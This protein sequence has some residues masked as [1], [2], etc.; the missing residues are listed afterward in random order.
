M[1]GESYYHT[2]Q[3]AQAIEQYE[4]A[5]NLYLSFQGWPD[6]TKLPET[7]RTNPR[8]AN[9]INWATSSRRTTIGVYDKMLVLMGRLDADRAIRGRR[10]V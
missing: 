3:Y 5:L 4:A 9:K 7:I 6:R 2:G 8:A 1:L 10:R